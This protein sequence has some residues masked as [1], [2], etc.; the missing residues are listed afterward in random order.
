MMGISCYKIITI[1]LTHFFSRYLA[2][3]CRRLGGTVSNGSVGR[4]FIEKFLE[5]NSP[6]AHMIREELFVKENSS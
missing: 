3:P 2:S 4:E 5:L 1:F 6:G